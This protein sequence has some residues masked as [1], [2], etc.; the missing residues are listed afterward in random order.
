VGLNIKGK[1]APQATTAAAR[2]DKNETL[3]DSDFEILE[4]PRWQCNALIFGRAGEGKSTFPLMYAPHP[5][6]QINFD[7][8]DRHAV[9]KALEAGRKV[10]RTH[11]PYSSTDV[12]GLD[13]TEAMKVGRTAMDKVV[14]NFEIAVRESQRGNVRTISIDTGTEYNEIVTIAV[15][16]HL[17]KANDYGRSKDHINRAWW[18]I[19]NTA[20][21]GN[22]HLIVLARDRE[23]W[24]GSEPSGVFTFRGPEVMNDGV[25]W[26]AQIR[27]KRAKVVAGSKVKKTTKEFELFI[28]KAGVNIAEL[29]EVYSQE[30]W[31][32][33]GGP[34]VMACVNQYDGSEPADWE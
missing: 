32:A 7:N 13:E 23:I 31:D 30:D 10:L 28:T 33:Y 3:E 19:F 26:A 17:G 16:G 14:K 22:A 27:L 18:H 29:G 34:F 24:G 2:R 9:R 5:V 1:G 8:R 6:A 20:R 21:E 25:D 15:R 12:T 4:Q 11:I